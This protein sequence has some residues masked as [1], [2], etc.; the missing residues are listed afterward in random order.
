MSRDIYGD[1][2]NDDND[3]INMTHMDNTLLRQFSQLLLM[4]LIY[5]H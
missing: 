4:T 2:T 3:A 1:D 5:V